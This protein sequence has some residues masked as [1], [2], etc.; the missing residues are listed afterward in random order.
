MAKI[1][2]KSLTAVI[3]N[4]ENAMA[5]V[6]I[7]LGAIVTV[8]AVMG[9]QRI[10]NTFTYT[11]LAGWGQDELDDLTA[12]VGDTWA[13]NMFGKV[14]TDYELSSVVGTD[15][16]LPV[17]FVSEYL[18]A[19]GE[20]TDTGAAL[21]NNCTFA[22]A[23]VTGLRGRSARGRVFIAG[24]TENALLSQNTVT[25]TWADSVVAA[26]EAVRTAAT[27]VSWTEV[28]ASRMTNGVANNPAVTRPVTEYLYT[29][30]VLD[31][32]RR[33]LPLRGT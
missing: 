27:G 7:P 33:R 13:A 3:T 30:N 12:A 28:I 1:H 20:G 8:N 26:L 32:M 18:D 17:G 2:P 11:H 6:P 15:Q 9:L 14:S 22:V 4:R 16:R 5:F 19:N 24:L 31:S 29:D 25:A 23:R 10:Q 21:P